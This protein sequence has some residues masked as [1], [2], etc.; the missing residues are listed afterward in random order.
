MSCAWAKKAIMPR[1]HLNR[2]RI[3]DSEA[4]ESAPPISPTVD[5]RQQAGWPFLPSPARN[6]P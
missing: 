6:L 1:P 4:L 2:A 5:S 3:D